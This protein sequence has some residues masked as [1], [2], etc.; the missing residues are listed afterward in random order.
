MGDRRGFALVRP[1]D[2][3]LPFAFVGAHSNL[4]QLDEQGNLWV[5]VL[6]FDGRIFYIG[7]AALAQVP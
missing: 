2:A 4:L 1:T 5:G 3:S 6:N 7:A